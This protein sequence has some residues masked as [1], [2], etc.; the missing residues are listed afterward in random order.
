MLY[1]CFVHI[2]VKILITLFHAREI[3]PRNLID[4]PNCFKHTL[5]SKCERLS[6]QENIHVLKCTWVPAVL[7]VYLLGYYEPALWLKVVNGK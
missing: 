4:N 5:N 2:A 1:L 3:L 7:K 6:R